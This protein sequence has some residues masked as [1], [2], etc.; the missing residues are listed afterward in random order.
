MI[1]LNH[2]EKYRT[3]AP[4]QALINKVCR[5]LV[6]LLAPI[7][8]H[9]CEEMWQMIGDGE[10]SVSH[11]PWPSYD[12]AALEQEV[13]QIVAQVN[14]KLRGRFDVPADSTEDR[15]REIVLADPK[16]QE[17]VQHKPLKKFIYVPRKLVNLVV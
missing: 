16:I 7:V 17:F 10:E 6:E 12:D 14:G 9:V 2:A 4:H 3:K 5:T 15:I 1:L 8:P 13:I 11:A